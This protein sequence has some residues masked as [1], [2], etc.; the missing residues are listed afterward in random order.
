M[1]TR[2]TARQNFLHPYRTLYCRG[3]ST[4][5]GLARMPERKQAC[6][7]TA[8]TYRPVLFIA[9]FML[10]G[11]CGSVH[12]VSNTVKRSCALPSM[13]VAKLRNTY[14]IRNET[15]QTTLVY[16]SVP[17]RFSIVS[18]CCLT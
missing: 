15:R 7:N 6:S 18:Q 3:T 12:S 5:V 13:E 2:C 8:H 11:P 1:Q 14:Q 9:F 4:C 17:C 16:S 10:G